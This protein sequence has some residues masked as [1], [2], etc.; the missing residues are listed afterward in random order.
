MINDENNNNREVAV[1]CS[2]KGDKLV[3]KDN[4]CAGFS[5]QSMVLQVGWSFFPL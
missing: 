2:R 4:I 3:G 1:Y 5:V